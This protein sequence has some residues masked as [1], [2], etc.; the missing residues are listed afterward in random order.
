M[1][2]TGHIERVGRR[3]VHARVS[4]W[5]RKGKSQLGRYIRRWYVMLMGIR[6][7]AWEDVD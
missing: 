6:E 3:E 4:M 1:G 7:I 2:W 5:K